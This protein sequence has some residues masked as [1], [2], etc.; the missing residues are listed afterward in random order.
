MTTL[1]A[2][3]CWPEGPPAGVSWPT[4]DTV[5]LLDRELVPGT[6]VSTLCRFGADR[7]RLSEAIFEEHETAASLNFAALPAPLRLA[8]KHYVWQLINHDAPTPLYRVGA[9]RASIRTILSAWAGFKDF[10]TWLHRRQIT[11]FCDV[12]HD[13]LDDYL[14]HVGDQDITLEAKFRRTVEV[15]RLWS[16]RS[17][18]PASMRLPVLPPWAGDPAGELFG[19]ARTSRENRTPRIAEATMAALLSWSLRFVEDFAADIVAA[20]T[21]YVRLKARTPEGRRRHGPVP[22]RPPPGTVER[23][24]RAYLDDVKRR[25]ACLPGKTS[26][27]GQVEVDWRHVGMILERS[28]NSKT[29]SSPA[30]QLLLAAGVPVAD[31]AY[32]DTAI[33]TQLDGQPWHAGPIAYRDAKVLARHLSTACLVVIA[34]LSGARPGEVLN[35]R[36]D[37]ISHDDAA[38]M[39]LM[40]GVFFKNAVDVSGNKIP[41]GAPRRDPWVVV[42]PVADAVAVLQRLHDDDLLFPV[43]L[44]AGR[45]RP[46][47]I[48]RSGRARTESTPD[49]AAFIAW[50]NDYCRPRGLPPIPPD[51]RGGLS[52]SRFRRTL[53]WFIRRR[54]RGLVA[55]AIQYGHVHTR[56]IQGYAGDYNS[57]FPDE[58]A[59]EDFLARMEELAADEQALAGGE[60]V[61]GPAAHTY[62]SRVSAASKQFGGH[63]ITSAKQARDLLGNPL[64]QIFHGDGMTCVFEPAQARC[65]IRGSAE[66]P[67]VTPDIDDCQPRC[68]NIAR[69]DRDITAVRAR[70]DELADIVN[71]SLAP[72]LRHA[73]E[74]QELSRLAAILQEHQ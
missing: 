6:D 73:R 55:G 18:L 68:R 48:T 9:E 67:M 64:L 16:Y 29:A 22:F 32:L 49:V 36:R 30:G 1:A 34:Y 39:W 8:A 11:Q 61:S 26:A 66:D 44:E 42:A 52:I 71:D 33:T 54:P 24:M 57:G 14:S 27:D 46:R 28:F 5:V 7:W 65:Q 15:R 25:G 21:E 35:L 72:P 4:P 74:R 12:T 2:T 10:L 62:R 20:H 45:S 23:Q 43:T 17:I 31:D 47:N 50:V 63:V 70:H 56:L 13:L 19:R 53:A 37:C 69:T 3:D 38:D 59:F 58:Y 41:A 60:H 51:P 40:S